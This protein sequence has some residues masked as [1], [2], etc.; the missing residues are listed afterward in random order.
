MAMSIVFLGVLAVG[1]C[2]LLIVAAVAV[3]WAITHDKPNRSR[4]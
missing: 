3:A 4:D 1:A 2:M